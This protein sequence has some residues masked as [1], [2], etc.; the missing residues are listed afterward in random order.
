MTAHRAL[1]T[2]AWP[3]SAWVS[4]KFVV[5]GL[6]VMSSLITRADGYSQCLI[7]SDEYSESHKA[8]LITGRDA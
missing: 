7:I 3:D 5:L 1:A 8:K 4:L 6:Q 2:V